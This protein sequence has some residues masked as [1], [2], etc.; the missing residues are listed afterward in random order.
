MAAYPSMLGTHF[1]HSVGYEADDDADDDDDDDGC[2]L[3]Q[4]MFDDGVEVL[5]C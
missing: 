5:T 1:L 2:F 4:L 3:V